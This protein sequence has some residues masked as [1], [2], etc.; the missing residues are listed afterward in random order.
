MRFMSKQPLSKQPLSKDENQEMPDDV[1][2]FIFQVLL[3]VR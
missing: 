2:N 1:E 3:L